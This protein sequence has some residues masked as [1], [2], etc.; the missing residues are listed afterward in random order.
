MR[1]RVA[2][3]ERA[4]EEPANL[5]V[6]DER[7]ERRERAGQVARDDERVDLDAPAGGE[8]ERGRVPL[9]SSPPR[10]P[11]RRSASSRRALTR[12]PP[13]RARSER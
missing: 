2:A 8:V 7:R 6:I 13:P 10:A 12:V 4:A 9:D 3:G 5:A 1:G 11:S